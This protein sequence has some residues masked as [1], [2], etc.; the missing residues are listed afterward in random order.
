MVARS[1]N[2]GDAAVHAPSTVLLAGRR[3]RRESG[4]G[5]RVEPEAAAPRY[6]ER[7]IQYVSSSTCRRRSPGSS[8]VLPASSGNRGNGSAERF[9]RSLKENRS[10]SGPSGLEDLPA[11][12]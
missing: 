12:T 1:T 10:G 4:T 9:M 5:F 11:S 6:P 8:G 2:R 3:A 7:W